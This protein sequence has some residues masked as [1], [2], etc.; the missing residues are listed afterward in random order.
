MPS[1]CPFKAASR[2]SGP[3]GQDPYDSQ[4]Q[5]RPQRV[6]RGGLKLPPPSAAIQHQPAGQAAIAA[7]QPRLPPQPVG[8]LTLPPISAS[9][10][11]QPAGHTGRNVPGFSTLPPADTSTL[12]SSSPQA[13]AVGKPKANE[14]IGLASAAP[15]SSL[16]KPSTTKQCSS[17]Y[18]FLCRYGCEGIYKTSTALQNH[19]QNFHNIVEAAKVIGTC[20]GCGRNFVNDTTWFSHA[21]QGCEPPSDP[22]VVSKWTVSPPTN[23]QERAN[24]FGKRF[25]ACSPS[26][27]VK[28][29]KSSF[30]EEDLSKRTP[31]APKKG[32]G[33]LTGTPETPSK[34]PKVDPSLVSEDDIIDLC[35][36]PN[37]PTRAHPSAAQLPDLTFADSSASP[38]SIG[39][40]DSPT[41][42]FIVTFEPDLISAAEPENSSKQAA[43]YAA[44]PKSINLTRLRTTNV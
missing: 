30:T 19:M 6:R 12:F 38:C 24:T 3:A 32:Y 8:G 42:D 22:D 7:S 29:P 33:W 39:I 25:G 15:P 41:E 35:S 9:T 43:S 17:Q 28:R 5:A 26:D 18:V 14:T 20:D 1:S 27:G 11:D 36:P 23:D 31:A 10:R 40:P 34:K 4:A 16:E 2:Q 44:I 37:S 21:G 13:A